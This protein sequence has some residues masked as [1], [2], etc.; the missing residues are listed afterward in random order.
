[1]KYLSVHYSRGYVIYRN[2][3][4]AAF[5]ETIA[6]EMFN[7][8]IDHDIGLCDTGYTWRFLPF[9]VSSIETH[10]GHQK[11]PECIIRMKEISQMELMNLDPEDDVIERELSSIEEPSQRSHVERILRSLFCDIDEYPPEE[12]HLYYIPK[13]GDE[14]AQYGDWMAIFYTQ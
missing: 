10:F 13:T 12:R 6:D 11:Q 8:F 14:L 3:L 9:K 1:M 2:E 5:G 4:V 7:V